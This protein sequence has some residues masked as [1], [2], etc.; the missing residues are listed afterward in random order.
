M[1][2]M[3]QINNSG[4]GYCEVDF[5]NGVNTST[6]D[7]S[8]LKLVVAINNTTCTSSHYHYGNLR[9][10]SEDKPICYIYK[11]SSNNYKLFVKLAPN[12]QTNINVTAQYHNKFT[13]INEGISSTP[14]GI[15]SSYTNTW[16]LE[17]STQKES[18]LKL[19]TGD[20]TI[21]GNSK[22]NDNL[23]IIGYN[24]IN[25]TSSRDVGL[26]YERYQIANDLGTGDIVNDTPIYIDTI[27]SQATVT[28]LTQ[29]KFSTNANASNDF[30]NGWWIKIISGANVNQVRKI[31]GYNGAQRIA[32]LETQLTTQNPTTGDTINFYNN[33]YVV[34]YYNETN[35][36]FVLGYTSEKPNNGIIDINDTA[37]LQIRKLDVTDTTDSFNSSSGS[38]YLLGGISI[39]NTNNAS[40]STSGGTI[41]ISGGIGVK[42][43]VRIGDN[44]GIG[45][46]GFTT[47]E[48]IHIRKSVA[49]ARLEHNTN[50]YSYIDFVENNTKHRYGILCDSQLS[51]TYTTNN[52]TPNNS[53]KALTINDV[54]YIGI[55]TTTNINSPLVMNKNNFI[56]TNSTTGYIGLIAGATNNNSNTIG[57]RLVLFANDK[58]TNEG[59]V[60][61]YAGNT[62]SG[63][64]SIFTNNDIERVKVNYDGYVNILSTQTSNNSTTGA[65]II[66]GGASINSTQ[67]A[68]SYTNGG[69]FTVNGGMSVKKDTYIAG[70]VYIDGNITA[71]GSITAPTLTSFNPINCTF[72]EY[73]SNILRTTTTSTFGNLTFGF[74]VSP[75]N[76]SENCSIEFSLPGR[77]TAFT[78][79]FDVISTCSGYTDNTDIIPLM[80][81]LSYGEIGTSRIKIKFQSVST[82]PHYFQ[83]TAS[84]IQI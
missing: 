84:Y 50:S 77:T 10:D 40:S 32:I 73:Y 36:T 18:N 26:L 48:S 83:V 2:Y 37:N 21:E 38:I 22:I 43:D 66:N 42:K 80:N 82:S 45:N 76:A 11:D 67:N 63:N 64:V 51:L 61:L 31:T 46:G 8:G 60:N 52:S 75:S 72:I 58:L 13:L 30:Y 3:G 34:N 25:T 35:D 47:E 74:T 56:S 9:F 65:L 55:N 53:N 17:W 12:S 23:P 20:L 24:N 15:S 79:C 7:I 70:N 1:V 27:P 28:N 4:T 78:K 29:I 69:S 71:L 68:T 57:S 6:N 41:T 54:G 62:S 33:H 81:V 49:S 16:T 59:C 14:S 19:S 44:L 39:N 5:N